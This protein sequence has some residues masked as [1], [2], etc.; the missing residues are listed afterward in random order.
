MDNDLGRAL[1]AVGPRLRTLRRQRETTLADLSTETGISVSTLSRLESGDRRPTL[2]LLLPLAKAHGVTLDELVDA[3]PTGDPRIH[4]RPTTRHG[5][6]YLPLTR[7]AGGIQAYK[8]V[9]PPNIRRE[10]DPRTHEGYEWL[11]VL[12]GRLR[13]IL[14]EHD[15]ILTPGEAAEFDTR[16]PHWFGTAAPEPV[17]FLSLFGKQG[18]RAH[19]RTTPKARPE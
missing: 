8:L 11:Y 4:L 13:L 3:P 19:L 5:M 10:P 6:T 17:E 7:R 18:E 2:E 15:V 16:V 1:D 9:I 12:N 14:G